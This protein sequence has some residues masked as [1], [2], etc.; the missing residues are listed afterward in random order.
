L[1]LAVQGIAVLA[2]FDLGEDLDAFDPFWV[3]RVAQPPDRQEGGFNLM[4]YLPCDIVH[5]QCLPGGL[6]MFHGYNAEGLEWPRKIEMS[7]IESLAGDYRRWSRTERIISHIFLVA[8]LGGVASVF[9][10]L[11]VG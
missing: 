10:P 2:G 8:S 5:G 1:R 3:Q 11:L 9:R 4:S 7:M 6:K